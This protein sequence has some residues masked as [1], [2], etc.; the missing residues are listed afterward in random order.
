MKKEPRRSKCRIPAFSFMLCAALALGS[1]G[2]RPAWAQGV[3][4][5]AATGI[6]GHVG[7]T[8]EAYTA[9]GISNRR[10]P[11]SVMLF[12]R[13]SSASS[14]VQYGFQF[15]LATEQSA[16]RQAMNRLSAN[17]AYRSVRISAGDMSPVLSRFT[18]N[19]TTTRGGALEIAPG[20]M[21]VTLMGG[22]L[23]RRV[24]DPST[25]LLR[26]SF[27]EMLYAARVGVGKSDGSHIHL[28]GLVARDAAGSLDDSLNVSPRENVSITPDVGL[29]LWED[30]LALGATYTLSAFS[31]DTRASESDANVTS[32]LGFF[33][34]RV[35]SR[36]GYATDLH[37]HLRLPEG[38]VR[39]SYERIQPGFRSLGIWQTRSD[40]AT[41]RLE[42]TLHLADRTA[43]VGVRLASSRNNLEG[44]R[45][46][47]LK[48]RSVYLFGNLKASR[49]TTIT[50]A[51]SNFRT[52]NELEDV[53]VSTDLSDQKNVAQMFMVG[54]AFTVIN[55]STTHVITTSATYQFL[56]DKAADPDSPPVADFDNFTATAAYAVAFSGGTS[57]NASAGFLS[58]STFT[59]DA[60][61]LSLTIGAGQSFASR[62][63]RLGMTAGW[64]R[65]SLDVQPAIAELSQLSLSSTQLSLKLVGSYR[66][67]SGSIVRLSVRGLRSSGDLTPD[68]R[69]LRTVLKIEHRF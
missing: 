54:P 18:I 58:S 12:G 55:G 61:A 69:E 53:P 21:V 36:L 33:T 48:R 49:V 19:G 35:G 52:L 51:Y 27:R 25:E 64:S 38:G 9:S 1:A 11:A 7:F 22:R 26:P 24:G 3:G 2:N 42:P 66:V 16:T 29:V 62:R 46:A 41:F 20:P 50:A 47:T 37:A 65:N 17:V 43:H 14:A 68:F 59:T 60:G 39:M 6:S 10:D 23:R 31:A 4:A 57:F 30:R 34:P 40:Q 8:G 13:A 45:A 32:M 56:R 67:P 63:A 15:L 28:I 44:N 5:E